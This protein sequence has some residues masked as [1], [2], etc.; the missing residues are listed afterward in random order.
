[1][2][3][4]TLPFHYAEE[5]ESTGMTALSWLPAYLDLTFVARLGASVRRH[6]GVREGAQGWTDAQ[7]VV[8]LMMLNLA[9][10]ETVD[11]LRLLEKDE[12]LGRALLTA[13]THR[14]RRAQ[15]NRWRKE[16]S[17]TV[18]SPTVVFRYLNRFH[19]EAEE[20]G[21]RSRKAFIPAAN[22]TLIGTHKRQAC[23]CYK[24][25]KAYQ[26]LT[27]YWHEADLWTGYGK[28]SPDYRFIAI[29]ERLT[30]PPM[31][32]VDGEKLSVPVMEMGDGNWYKVTGMVTN[33]ELPGDELVRWYRQRC[34]KSLP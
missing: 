13:E 23:Y 4:A 31:F 21:R 27:T 18:R 28:N 5:D 24:K 33:R 10:G 3:H 6:V 20:A 16:R 1:M 26:P 22:A 29:R 12:G 11:D 2:Q 15:R 9:G 34:S 8:A 19:D 32:D 25:H 17:R 14:M 7:I 30:N